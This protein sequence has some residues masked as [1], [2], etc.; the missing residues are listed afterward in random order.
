VKVQ[1]CDCSIVI[2]TAFWEK[3]VPYAEET[4][5]DAFSLLLEEASIEGDGLCR[6]I[7]KKSGVTG[8]VVIPLTIGTVPMLL[9]LAMGSAGS[10]VFV[11][12]TRNV[13]KTKINLLPLPDTASFDLVQDRGNE[14]QL[15]EGCK[16]KG[17]EL[18]IERE[19]AIKLKLDICGEYP[20]VVYPHSDSL[21]Q[22]KGERYKGDNVTYKINRT[23]YKNI[24]G[25]TLSCK[26]EFGTRTEL[27][28]RRSLENGNEIPHIIDELTITAELLRDK[29]EFRHFGT[30][31]ITL[32]RLVLTAD[33][34]S[35]NSTEAVIGPLRY[36]AAGNVSAEVF[37][38]GENSA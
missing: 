33:E 4:I 26:K 27:W 30:F 29:Y 3:D 21:V 10:S 37:T 1:G 15:F 13:H 7:R 8:C 28:I 34:T 25:F 19:Q 22:G 31:T 35:I 9:Y 14:R 2:K 12:E 11:S 24:Y 23:E 17:F 18:R 6:A 20:S 16:V 36:Y 38:S 5:R 32:T